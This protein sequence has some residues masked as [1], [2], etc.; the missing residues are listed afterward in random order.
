MLLNKRQIYL[1]AVLLI[2]LLAV[3]A[4]LMKQSFDFL[5]VSN[6]LDLNSKREVYYGKVYID[7]IRI[8]ENV[9]DYVLFSDI[10]SLDD[11]RRN[12]AITIKN[13]MELHA[14]A[15]PS[16]KQEVED[17]IEY[18]RAY[19]SF[20]EKE[21][22]SAIQSKNSPDADIKYIQ[23]RHKD[24]ARDLKN[25]AESV[26]AAGRNEMQHFIEEQIIGVSGRFTFLLIFM[27]LA[28]SALACQFA[29]VI[30]PF[31]VRHLHMG[32]LAGHIKSVVLIVDRN[33]L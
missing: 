29:Y 6:E 22:I 1:M 16:K 18:T 3:A 31:L 25:K 2:L 21:V 23:L 28:L 8:I 11:F 19:S 32:K 27:L 24:Y 14:V 4:Y 15:S 12:S 7:V 13:Q 30:K 26:T 9:Q 33:G 5:N 20:V 10:R 17:L